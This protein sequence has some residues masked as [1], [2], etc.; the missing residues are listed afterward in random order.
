MTV[1]IPS[2][3]E[4]GFAGISN[5]YCRIAGNLD[6]E[7]EVVK[8]VW[9]RLADFPASGRVAAAGFAAGGRIYFGTGLEPNLKDKNDFWEFD[10]A[11]SA[12]T[13]KMDFLVLITYATASLN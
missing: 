3:L 6:K 9:S 2:E 1:S 5:H 7:I 13:R 10:P 4:E 12:W 11:T 8:S